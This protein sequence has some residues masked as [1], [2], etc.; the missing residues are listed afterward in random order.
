MPVLDDWQ[1]FVF[2]AAEIA[3]EFTGSDLSFH[4]VAVDD[5]STVAFDPGSVELA[6]ASC[7]ASIEVV[8]LAVNLGH[9]RAIAAGLVT[10]ARREGFD[11]V[12]IMDCDGEDRPAD[13][14]AL[15]D[16]NQ[17]EPSVIV[18]ARR[19]ER[20]ETLA[21]KIGYFVYK[22]LFRV[23]TG[24]TI[25]FGNFSLLPIAAVRRLVYMPELWNNLPA[26]VMRSR[27]R[28]TTVPTR[29]GWRYFGTP[30]MNKTA[31]VVHGL[32]AI[33]VYSDLI[34]V[35]MLIAA[36][37]V[38]C[39]S[40]AAFVG[41]MLI[42][43]LTD[44]AVPGWATTAAGDLLIILLLTAVVA[45]ATLLVVLSCRS[46]PP[47]VPMQHA[48]VYLVSEKNAPSDSPSRHEI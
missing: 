7:V 12:V 35:R 19:T 14:A 15:L 2:L 27:M 13:I 3:K 1:S 43:L 23:M 32:S 21:F 41:V 38:S 40:V 36:A 26:A 29:R 9:Q 18:L 28:Y 44:L 17:K 10:L 20:T 11:A 4:I 34:F 16:A 45:V 37:L 5:G 48:W 8:R 42:R 47:V 25:N 46:L 6:P 30:R 31:L 22:A 39:A 24:Q 33:S